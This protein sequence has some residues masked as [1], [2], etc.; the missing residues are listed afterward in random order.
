MC[1]APSDMTTT[2]DAT[3]APTVKAAPPRRVTFR[4]LAEADPSAQ[5]NQ[6]ERERRAS[7]PVQRKGITPIKKIKKV[8]SERLNRDT[9]AKR[10][11][12][13]SASRKHGDLALRAQDSLQ[14]SKERRRSSNITLSDDKND[15]SQTATNDNQAGNAEAPNIHEAPT[16]TPAFARLNRLWAIA[17][18][19]R[20]RAVPV[21]VASPSS[22]VHKAEPEQKISSFFRG[23]FSF[24]SDEDKEN[25]KNGIPTELRDAN[26]TK[27]PV[28]SYP[29]LPKNSIPES[30]RDAIIKTLKRMSQRAEEPSAEAF[31]TVN[32]YRTCMQEAQ[33]EGQDTRL[34]PLVMELVKGWDSNYPLLDAQHLSKS[35]SLIARRASIP[36][37]QSGIRGPEKA[38]FVMR[39]LEQRGI[40]GVLGSDCSVTIVCPGAQERVTSDIGLQAQPIVFTVDKLVD[41]VILTIF[42]QNK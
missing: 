21:P 5:K 42:D 12:S 11:R 4:E 2:P 24:G 38:T 1:P 6:T 39:V 15:K 9:I 26:P 41:E 28:A 40:D 22:P 29:I 18:K 19:R 32:D 3:N 20:R 14:N 27:D 33:R 37:R 35:S 30:Y 10:G 34:E 13:A 31:L 7:A 36:N 23:L 17:P 8:V 25:N 16:T